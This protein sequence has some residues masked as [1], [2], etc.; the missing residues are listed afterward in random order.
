MLH[1]LA[2]IFLRQSIQH[3]GRSKPRAT[4]LQNPDRLVLDFAGSHLKTSNKQIASNMDPIREVRLA[5]F[6]PDVARVVID[7]RQPAEY[8]INANGN[9]VTVNDCHDAKCQ[10]PF[11]SP[12]PGF[13]VPAQVGSNPGTIQATLK[14]V[15]GTYCYCTVGCGKKEDT[16]P[17]TVIIS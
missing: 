8:N 12:S 6:T 3:V 16:N 10:F 4:R 11:S 1:R 7:L 5:Q 15:P 17:K 2:K 14:N 9:S 13:S